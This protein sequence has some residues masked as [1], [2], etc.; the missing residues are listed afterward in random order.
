LIKKGLELELF[1]ELSHLD[2]YKEIK[3]LCVEDEPDVAEWFLK[4]F[5]KIIP[6]VFVAKDGAEGLEIF[7]RELPDVVITDVMMPSMNG[8]E[9]SRRIKELAPKTKIIVVTAY[10]SSEYLM[11]AIEIGVDRFLTKP[12]SLEK[13]D[14]S[15]FSCAKI[16]ATEKE[17]TKKRE[18]LV[19]IE[20][21]DSLT[22]LPNRRKLIE[23]IELCDAPALA[24]LNI[25]SFK[26]IND[27]YGHT[28]GDMVLLEIAKKLSSLTSK[29]RYE[30]YKLSADEY[31]VFKE[32]AGKGEFSDYIENLI[33]RM[34]S[35]SFCYDE[36]EISVSFTAGIAIGKVSLLA[37]ADM[38]LKEAKREK[39]NFVVY[40]E[41]L[42]VMEIY[43]NN[44]TWSKRLRTAIKEDRIVAYFQP[45]IDNR[46]MEITKYECLAR[47]I[48]GLGNSIAPQFFLDISKKNRLYPRI[49]KKMLD[50]AFEVFA[51]KEYEFSINLCVE[52]MLDHMTSAYICSKLEEYKGR[53]KV[54]FEILESERI[55]EYGEVREFIRKVKELGGKISI[56]DF[57]SGYSNFEHILRLNVDYIKIDA[58]MI[59]HIDT[60]RNSQ[61]I[62]DTIVGFA[63]KLNIRTIAEFVHSESVFE[64][65]RELGVDMSQGYYFSAPTSGI[66]L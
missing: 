16:V 20:N 4:H 6:T 37:K 55:E 10:G 43:S 18:E 21:I 39:K 34:E 42:K 57:G 23:I 49:T 30:I 19:H 61:I 2:S 40:E 13:L 24:I 32:S 65:V 51:D 25:D 59:K 31:A 54:A 8:L 11:E 14:K 27:F 5:S 64:K 12:L 47:M 58:S 17:L 26:E 56:D 63:K 62:V 35:E 15:F 48:D 46:T 41:S 22:L 45:I 1:E 44:L 38:A 52:D 7:Q 33:E 36:N 28:V 66:R 53:T 50:M 29:D 9:L 3:L 60:D